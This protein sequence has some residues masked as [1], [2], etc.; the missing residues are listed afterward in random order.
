MLPRGVSVTLVEPQYP[1]NVGHVARLVMNFGVE[2]LYL[3]KPKVDMSMAG[4]YASHAS[5][6]LDDAVVASLDR[7][8]EENELMIAT[9]AVRAA[10]KSNIIRRTVGPDRLHEVL[11]SARTSSLVFGRDST[12][13]R[14]EEIK[15]CDATTTIET[16]ARYRALN[17]GHAA[18]IVLYAASRGKSGPR[19]AQSRRAREVF[20][21]S[22][23]ELGGASRLPKHK[24][25]GL[26]E[27]GKRIASTSRL[28]DKQ[29]NLLSGVLGKA[30][31]TID[32]LQDSDSKT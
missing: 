28:T 1:V 21:K 8:R 16:S 14:N 11:S 3:V 7:V 5:K 29:L 27:A 25:E 19:S 15:L 13:L 20:A 22:L 9:T 24:A 32:S 31:S 26:F 4:V 2:R 17:L 12:G 6:V 30:L 10:S 18:A 23:Q